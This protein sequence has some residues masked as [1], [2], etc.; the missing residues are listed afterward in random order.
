MEFGIYRT[1]D[2]YGM[3]RAKLPCKNAFE[4]DGR[5]YI[6]I[7]SIQDLLKLVREK[8]DIIIHRKEEYI[9]K[10]GEVKRKELIIL[11]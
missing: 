7:D 1:K 9:R 4:K 3:S 2:I 8:G 11:K 10:D 5:C 6:N